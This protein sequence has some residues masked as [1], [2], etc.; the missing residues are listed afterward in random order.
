VDSRGFS[1][2]E[3]VVALIVVGATLVVLAPVLFHVA[4]QRVEDEGVTE[5][6]AALRSEANRLSLLT[7]T[8]LDAQAGCT[9]VSGDLPHSRC[10]TITTVSAY[11]RTVKVKITPTNTLVPKDSVVFTRTNVRSNPFNTAP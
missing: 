6:E 10:V 4:N 3:S 1:L 9:N 5:R 7:F 11:E 8:S 2:I